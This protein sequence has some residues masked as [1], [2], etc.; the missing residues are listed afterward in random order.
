MELFK[1]IA[2]G[3]ALMVSRSAGYEETKE[4]V[5][6]QIVADDIKWDKHL[7]LMKQF[8]EE[9]LK[10]CT[11]RPW[12]SLQKHCYDK[13]KETENNTLSISSDDSKKV[14]NNIKLC[15]LV[16]AFIKERDIRRDNTANGDSSL[17]NLFEG[18]CNDKT[19][20]NKLNEMSRNEFRQDLD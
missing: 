5:N 11:N 20:L 7:R 15:T 4:K 18:V 17:D 6:A 10:P 12:Q 9:I 19:I 14:M 1:K 2:N 16:D 8:I 3:N 13:Y